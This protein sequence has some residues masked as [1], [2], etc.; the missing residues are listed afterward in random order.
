MTASDH[1]VS[2][3]VIPL[4]DPLVEPLLPLALAG[5]QHQ[6]LVVLGAH[7]DLVLRGVEDIQQEVTLARAGGDT[8]HRISDGLNHSETRPLPPSPLR[9]S[10]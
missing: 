6:V 5:M 10:V 1:C 2:F 9:G 8:E 4:V 7:G 3:V